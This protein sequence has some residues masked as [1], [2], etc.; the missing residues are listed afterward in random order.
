MT[1]LQQENAILARIKTQYPPCCLQLN[2][3][4]DIILVGTYE[5]EKATGLR[6]GTIELLEVKKEAEDGGYTLIL[7]DEVKN[8]NSPEKMSAILDLKIIREF[9]TEV[10]VP[11]ITAHST[12]TL[13]FWH[14]N[15]SN[16]AIEFKESIDVTGDSTVLI[17]SVHI[18]ETQNQD[19]LTILCTATDGSAAIV[20]INNSNG[21]HNIEYVGEMHDLECWTGDFGNN[22]LLNNCFFTGGD[23]SVIKLFD[24]RQSLDTSVWS[25]SRIHEAGVVSIKTNAKTSAK[26]GN[27]NTI[28]TGSYDDNIRMFD[29]RMMGSDVYLGKIP[30]LNIRNKNLN[31]G[32]WRIIDTDV[33]D[34]LL[35]CCMYN[36]AKIVGIDYENNDTPFTERN[37]VKSGHES[38]CYG[39][40]FRNGIIA[41]CSFYDNSLQIWRKS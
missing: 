9:E 35:V 16:N 7:V 38:M 6:Y 5:L 25:N 1:D 31:G 34:E 3:D 18:K 22:S 19:M 28:L 27:M 15:K 36:G 12:G 20:T 32:V 4:A 8:T 21:N 30:P 29:L 37:Y 33:E 40:D 10:D 14:F 41:T 23:D 17:T 11:F 2:A 39:G 26:T 13:N 24:M